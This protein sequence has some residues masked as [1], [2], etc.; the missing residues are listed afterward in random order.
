MCTTGTLQP[1]ASWVMQPILPVAT[2]SGAGLAIFASLRSRSAAA[3]LRLQQVI[4]PCRAAAEMPLRHID[5]LEPGGGEK[6]FRPGVE[7]LPMLHRASRMVGD[8]SFG[9]GDAPPQADAARAS[10]PPRSTSRAS[11]AIR[12]A[13][14]A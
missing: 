12:A 13:F 3:S 7:S 9:D 2:R 5:R 14:S 10:R 8:P 6:L 11:R 4:G 1:A